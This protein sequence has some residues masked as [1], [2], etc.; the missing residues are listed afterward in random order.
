MFLVTHDANNVKYFKAVIVHY[1]RSQL[2]I[3][4]NGKVYK[5]S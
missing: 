1:C 4:F 2:Q 5:L 3:K